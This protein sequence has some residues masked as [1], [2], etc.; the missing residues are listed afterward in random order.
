MVL[1]T[2]APS[3]YPVGRVFIFSISLILSIL[4]NGPLAFDVRIFLLLIVCSFGSSVNLKNS[5]G[6]GC[7]ILSRKADCTVRQPVFSLFAATTAKYD[8]TLRT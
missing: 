3:F 7:M 4:L 6:K 2:S 1:E 5:F 8:L